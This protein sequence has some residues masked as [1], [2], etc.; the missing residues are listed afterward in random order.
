MTNNKKIM[1][2]ILFMVSVLPLGGCDDLVVTDNFVS[3]TQPPVVEEISETTEGKLTRE[4][5]I[6]QATE[7]AIE[8]HDRISNDEET[9]DDQPQVESVPREWQ[10]ALG[11]ARGYISIMSF[12]REGLGGQLDFEGFPEDAIEWA[13]DQLDNEVDWYAQA[14][15]SAEGYLDIM[16]FSRESLYGQLVFEGFT[17]SQAQHGSD[18]A[19]D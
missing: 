3:E 7:I 1:I 18:V 8:L 19:F 5:I 16:D 13:L 17:S 2:G 6:E 4:E 11:S 10:S 9:E 12:S 15:L 14:V